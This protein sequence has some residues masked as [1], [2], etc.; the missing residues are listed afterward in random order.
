MPA[1][2]QLRRQRDR[3]RALVGQRVTA[4]WTA[5][6]PGGGRLFPGAPVLLTFDGG[7]QAELAWRK[8]DDLSITWN[9]VDPTAEPGPPHGHH[10]EWRPAA[11]DEV[12][13]IVGLA[14]TGI[15][16]SEGPY[17]NDVDLTAGAPL[18]LDAV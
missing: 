9:T 16:V 15:A 7:D 17:F 4:G 6:L 13:A 8:W 1:A 11:P 10:H 18:P 5:W 14:V 2:D 3:L 12:A